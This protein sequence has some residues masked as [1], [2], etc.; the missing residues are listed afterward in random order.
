[1][2]AFVYATSVLPFNG[3]ESSYKPTINFFL[4][5]EIYYFIIK[6]NMI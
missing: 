6:K 5:K 1:M 3:E 2:N 4:K